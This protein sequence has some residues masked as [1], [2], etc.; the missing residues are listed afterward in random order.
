[1]AD[2]IFLWWAMHRMEIHLTAK[3]QAMLKLFQFRFEDVRCGILTEIKDWKH[4]WQHQMKPFEPFLPMYDF[5]LAHLCASAVW[6][7]QVLREKNSMFF[8][9]FMEKSWKY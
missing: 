6:E 8:P 3:S 9:S 2:L 7:S 5:D 4:T 1:M